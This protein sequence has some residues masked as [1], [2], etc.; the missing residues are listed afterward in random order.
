MT[1]PIRPDLWQLGVPSAAAGIYAAAVSWGGHHDTADIPPAAWRFLTEL[2]G[3][4]LD[5]HLADLVRAGLLR[6]TPTGHRLA[7]ALRVVAE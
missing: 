6:P 3:Q 7:P 2:R 1:A 5:A 4:V